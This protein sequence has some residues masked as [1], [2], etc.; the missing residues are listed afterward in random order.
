[1]VGAR[2]I[3]L[4]PPDGGDGVLEVRWKE[5]ESSQEQRAAA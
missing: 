5:P 2:N 1:M 3:N 4:M